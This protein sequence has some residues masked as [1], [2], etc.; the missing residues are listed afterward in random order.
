MISSLQLLCVSTLVLLF[1]SIDE[2]RCSSTTLKTYIVYLDPPTN[3]NFNLNLKKEYHDWCMSFLPPAST[4]VRAKRL[5]HIYGEAIH[6]FAARLMDEE[7]EQMKKREGFVSAYLDRL[8][9]LHTTYTPEFLGLTA[10]DPMFGD[11]GYGTIVGVLDTGVTPNHPSFNGEGISPPPAKWNGTCNL[12]P[13]KWCNNKLIGF[14]SFLKGA[15]AAGHKNLENM[16]TFD[17]VGHGTHT[18]S[19]I[20]GSAVDR[21][22]MLGEANG[23]AVGM[24]PRAHLAIYRVCMRWGCYGS[25]VLAGI[26]A[27]INDG[28]DVL[29]IS[30]GGYPSNYYTD[31]IAVGAFRAMQKGIFVSC[32]AGNAGPY[33]YSIANEA[34]WT[35]TVGASSIDR[36]I[37]STVRLGDGQELNG[38]TLY[39][40][41]N[42]SSSSPFELARPYYGGGIKGKIVFC[43]EIDRYSVACRDESKV[44]SL[45]GVGT[46]RMSRWIQGNNTMARNHTIPFSQLN[47]D[48]GKKVQNYMNI[49]HRP[50]A[51]ILFN[52]T[53]YGASHTPSLVYFSSRGPARIS[54]GIL[55]PDIVG[56]GLNII[57]AYRETHDSR[58]EATLSNHSF[59]VLSG[60]SMSAP[61]LSGI[62]ALIKDTHPNWSPSAIKSAIM[63]TAN[64]LDRDGKPIKTEKYVP[65]NLFQM[66]AGH[67]NASNAIHPG[68]IYDISPQDYISFLCQLNYTQNQLAIMVGHKIDC[69]KFK[70]I[71]IKDLNYPS[72]SVAIEKNENNV[73]VTRTVTNVGQ[74]KSNYRFKL[75]RL[76]GVSIKVKP[77]KLKFS[78]LNKQISFKLTLKKKAGQNS[79]YSQGYLRWVCQE[80]YTVVRIP[81]SV[82]I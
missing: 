74:E 12:T 72:I 54:P 65:A 51:Y 23:T 40:P 28:I 38:E 49:T 80:N 73:T 66:G 6:G 44:E 42:F 53:V 47:Y 11:G 77:R 31:P 32:S 24:A 50:T 75:D 58:F 78:K 62:V 22:N 67:V 27:G 59:A 79:H 3:I 56:P 48:D 45:G 2:S 26:N 29:S 64:I 14:Q 81:I 15:I 68:L 61:H 4:A 57:A 1:L 69:S 71:L 25:D 46:I 17:D 35:L 16:T 63:T 21:A 34:P 70:K 37:M 5:V 8:L 9:K 82:K 33:Y 43:G 55:K 18:A 76:H 7:V 36:R 20:A 39:Q 10:N 30:L 60:T 13:T 41:K 52:H 19:T